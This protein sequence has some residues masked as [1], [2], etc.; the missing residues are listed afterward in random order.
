MNCPEQ[1]NQSFVIYLHNTSPGFSEDM[2]SISFV[3]L[4]LIFPLFFPIFKELYNWC[5]LRYTFTCPVH[6][7][8]FVYFS[9]IFERPSVA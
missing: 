8:S 9:F 6:C 4:C 2:Y 5:I 1:S 7:G 3:A